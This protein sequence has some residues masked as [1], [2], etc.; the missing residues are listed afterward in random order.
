MLEINLRG[1]VTHD[2]SELT[3]Q[4]LDQLT[5]FAMIIT[6]FEHFKTNYW[7]EWLAPLCKQCCTLP[8]P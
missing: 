6:A 2:L 4:T 3:G 7:M 5:H 1:K 8:Q